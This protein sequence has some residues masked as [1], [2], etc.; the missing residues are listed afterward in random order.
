[1][2]GTI[3]GGSGTDSSGV[4]MMD[5]ISN[6][7]T[8]HGTIETADMISGSAIVGYTTNDVVYNYGDVIGSVALDEGTNSFVIETGAILQSGSLVYLDQGNV[9]SNSGTISPGSIGTLENTSLVGNFTQTGNAAWIFDINS[10]F[11][12]DLLAISGTGNLGS[13][14]N[15][16]NLNEL[17]MPTTTGTYTLITAS[18]G[19]TGSFQ[20]GTMSG[21]TMPI[22]LTYTLTNS[23]TQEVLNLVT[24]TGTFYWRGAVDSV[25]ND[26]FVNGQDNW[27]RDPAGT[28]FIFGTPGVA[29]DVIFSSTND[30]NQV[31]TLGADF[32][33]NSLT[34]S[35]TNAVTIGGTNTLTIAAASGVGITVNS[36]AALTT[37]SADLLLS[38]NQSWTNNSSN[39]LNIN[40]PTITSPGNNNLTVDGTGTTQISS[41]IATGGGS[42]TK[43]GTGTLILVTSTNTYAGGTY[44]KNGNLL[45]ANSNALGVGNVNLTGGVLMTT[46]DPLTSATIPL[47]L[48]VGGNYTQSAPAVLQLRIIGPTGTAVNDEV[49]VA[50]KATLGGTFMP[51]YSVTNY[52]PIPPAGNYTDAFEVLHAAGGVSGTFNSFVDVHYDATKL[53]RW[54][55]VYNSNDV[56]LEWN[57]HP[58]SSIGSGSN[59]LTGNEGAVAN[60]IDLELGLPVPAVSKPYNESTGPA[61][62][63]HPG[64]KALITFLNNENVANLPADYNSLAPDELTSMFEIG[65]SFADVQGSN[66][67]TRLA[68]DRAENT[69]PP[70][71]NNTTVGLLVSDGKS[72]VGLRDDD[73]N[74]AP[75]S[76]SSGANAAEFIHGR[77]RRDFV[78]VDGDSN[79]P[80][81]NFNT[82]GVTVGGD[83]RVND[84]FVIGI[85][86]GYANTGA[87]LT[88]HGSVDVNSGQIGIYST[89]YGNGFYLN[90]MAIGGYNS[91][92]THR[93]ALGGIAQ[94]KTEGNDFNGLIS[95]GY[96]I[97]SGNVTLGPI[98][99][100]EYTDVGIRN[101]TEMGSLAPLEIESQNQ[102]SLESRVGFKISSL[103]NVHGVLVTPMLS[104][105]WLHEYLT[106]S[107]AL[108]S[109]FAAGA[110]N[111]FSVNGPQIGRDGVLL[112]TGVDVQWTPRF[113]TYRYYNGELGRKNYQLNS[114][115]GGVRLS[116]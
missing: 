15:T 3:Q 114:V 27:T 88:Q 2:S 60:V 33:I 113:G 51:D 73:K 78:H 75:A 115:T 12:S 69:P 81:Y 32:T 42:L 74:I 20:F 57:Q 89:I 72:T 65:R 102:E 108:D 105:A 85:M 66:I 14:S 109:Q 96:D 61:L 84:H 83:L 49:F 30:A 19:L 48:N 47:P 54:E 43:D 44:L 97:H 79:A 45:I 93:I 111:V 94:G 16:V 110:G 103:W 9:F 8:N 39:L 106:D 34:V 62:D 38:G 7:L 26:D 104:A 37:L 28:N 41:L 58:F 55:P 80:G 59:P 6:Q 90:S 67:E 31:T 101:Y 17:N 95:G 71:S 4:H 112:N 18:V 100:A 29:D 91:Y 87:T 77:Q 82:G 46:N 76:Y 107:Y 116:F 70:V 98:V 40:A 50:G 23:D 53:L 36:G 5:G 68:E 11:T 63:A 22:G 92:D 13:Y 1:M 99:A 24:S 86:A 25:W 21:T 35:D 56:M 64:L 52:N 10:S